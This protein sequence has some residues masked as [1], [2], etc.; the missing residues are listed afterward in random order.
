VI[1]ARWTAAVALVT[2]F[3]A[4]PSAAQE[5]PPVNDIRSATRWLNLSGSVRADYFSASRDLDNK[6]HLAGTSVWLKAA[7]RLGERAVAVL[8]GWIRN[9]SL[10]DS[11][12]TEGKLRQA[13]VDLTVGPLDLRIGKQLVP[14]GRVDRI[15]PTDNLTPRDFT[16]LVPED[17]DQRFG[18]VATKATLEAW[19]LAVTGIWLPLFEPSKIPI[20]AEPGVTF[21]E[22]T[23][24]FA[25]A[26]SQWAAKV[27]RIGQSFDWSLSY[28]DG[29]DLFPDLGI[30][31]VAVDPGGTPK[32]EVLLRHHRLRVFGADAATTLGRFGLRGEVA[33]ALTQDLDGRNPEVKNPYVFLVLGIDRT[34]REHLNLNVQYLFR[35]VI[36]FRDPE[37]IQDPLQRPVAIEQGIIANQLDRFQHGVSIRVSNKWLNETLEAEVAALYWF[38]RGDYAIRPKAIYAFTD[39]IRGTLGADVFRGPPKSFFGRI[40]DTSTVFAEVKFSF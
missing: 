3:W 31:R 12:A 28:F 38:T 25:L 5:T 22:I 4:I 24:S 32:V 6:E 30:G 21:R 29:F 11:E 13:Y 23:P 20:A 33:Y 40:R 2:V 7:P 19:G 39:R 17:D 9:S 37:S 18:T 1:G 35:A 8:E 36:N 15:N 34:L 16:L 27:E 10:F 26:R 14:W